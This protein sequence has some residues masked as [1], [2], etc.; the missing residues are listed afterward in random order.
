MPDGYESVGSKNRGKRVPLG[1]ICPICEQRHTTCTAHRRKFRDEVTG[2]RV[3]CTTPHVTPGMTVCHYHGGKSLV[4]PANPNYRHGRRA[5]P[6]F[7][8]S[9]YLEAAEEIRDDPE[10]GT[11]KRVTLLCELRMDELLRMIDERSGI[12]TIDDIRDALFDLRVAIAS[13]DEEEIETALAAAE[14]LTKGDQKAEAKAWTTLLKTA[15]DLRRAIDSERKRQIV[16]G[17]YV[18]REQVE[19]LAR[20]L[21]GMVAEYIPDR[22]A[23][24]ELLKRIAQRVERSSSASREYDAAMAIPA[25]YRDTTEAAAVG[26]PEEALARVNAR[27]K[28]A[29][30]VDVM[31]D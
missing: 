6:R 23:L 12:G 15:G 8:P 19:L 26:N 4:G 22:D 27:V 28:T 17:D 18:P 13:N 9:R 3:P 31:S 7:L 11:M 21:M 20:E 1:E 5:H 2:L 14:A 29:R 10:H 25:E 16:V 24:S 30:A